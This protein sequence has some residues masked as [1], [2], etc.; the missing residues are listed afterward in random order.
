[1]FALRAGGGP[2]PECSVNVNPC[3]KVVRAIADF[4]DWIVGTGIHIA[5]LNAN[6]RRPGYARNAGRLHAALRISGNNLHTAFSKTEQRESLQH[7][8]V[9]FCADNYSDG[10]RR[11]EA[12][13]FYIPANFAQDS[14]ACRGQSGDIGHLRAGHKSSAT[15]CR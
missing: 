13:P 7:G 3:A 2:E 8:C 5:D 4:T 1:M 10:W 15:I 14:T 12:V 11:K 6:D 9:D